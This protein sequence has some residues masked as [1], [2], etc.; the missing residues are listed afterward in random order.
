[1]NHS[2][3]IHDI[4]KKWVDGVRLGDALAFRSLFDRYY[5]QLSSFATEY[6][7]SYDAGREVAQEV[8][9]KIW[10]SKESFSIEGSLKSYLYRAVYHQALN[11]IEKE[12]RRRN[13]EQQAAI[14]EEESSEHADDRI[15]ASEV[16]IAIR[17]AVR[18]L[19]PKR[20]LVFVL[21]RQ[22]GLSIKE[23][24]QVLNVSPKTVENQMT[25]AM[26]FLRTK[27]NQKNV[28]SH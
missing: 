18:Q 9:I 3:N 22:H 7:K 1:M 12:T 11:Y 6:V 20:N 4:E 25:E 24:A 8:F 23:V 27:L 15:I 26:K 14:T 28:T 10:S 17:E 2:N 16:R 19:P 21:H 5:V 13:Y